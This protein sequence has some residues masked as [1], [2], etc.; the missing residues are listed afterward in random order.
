MVDYE[1]GRLD[2]VGQFV[3]ELHAKVNDLEGVQAETRLF[4]LQNNPSNVVQ[5]QD[6]K[7][8]E[9][10]AAIDTDIKTVYD[11]AGKDRVLL[12]KGRGFTILL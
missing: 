10:K 12:S 6:E 11:D 8:S 2:E 1:N 9:L 7:F 3:M 5:K 4:L